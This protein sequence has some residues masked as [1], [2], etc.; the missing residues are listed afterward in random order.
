MNSAVKYSFILLLLVSAHY[1][2]AE[3][4]NIPTIAKIA[5][6]RV[7]YD[8][9]ENLEHK[10]GPA[11]VCTGGHAHGGREWRSRQTGW[12]VDADGFYY[13][14]HGRRVIDSLTISVPPENLSAWKHHDLPPETDLPRRKLFFMDSVSLGMSRADVLQQLCGKLSPPQTAKNILF[15]K[16]K[17]D[18]RFNSINHYRITAW[19]AKL[20]FNHDRLVSIK[21]EAEYA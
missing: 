11:L 20:T 12:W 17:G 6:V 8:T 1:A 7:G 5:D 4:A 2:E 3:S 9:M 16:V 19:T 10:L 21:L 18:L 14:D 13:N 15:W